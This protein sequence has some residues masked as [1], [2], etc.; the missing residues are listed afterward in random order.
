MDKSASYNGL[1]NFRPSAGG[2]PQG[3]RVLGKGQV[4]NSAGGYTF[5]ADMWQR[6]D[7]FLI[8]G[9]DRG[10]YY[11]SPRQL[12]L[13]NAE[14]L[15]GC[16]G[17]NAQRTIQRI[18]DISVSGRAPHNEPCIFA[19]AV[20]TGHRSL[21]VRRMALEAVGRVCRTATHLFTF[22]GYI[23]SCGIRRWGR[24]LRGAVA[25]W[26]NEK[27]ASE[28]AYQVIK[29]RARN[30]WTHK[31]ALLLAHAKP[32]TPAHAALFGYVFA[33]ARRQEVDTSFEPLV[34]GFERLQRA[35][36]A[37]EA[38]RLILQYSLPWEAV[39]GEFLG[40]ARV[41]AALLPHMAPIA[42]IRTLNRMTIAGLLAP[43]S[44]A[45]KFVVG[46]LSDREWLRKARLH[47][48]TYFLMER[49]YAQGHGL[50]GGLTWQPLGAV[51]DALDEAFYGA[52]DF[53]P[54]SGKNILLALDV[55]G[56]MDL[57]MIDGVVTAREGAAIMAMAQAR[58][59]EHTAFMAFS[60]TFVPLDISKGMRLTDVV[61]A[62]RRLP[63]GGTD[64]ALPML[65]ALGMRQESPRGSLWGWG[66]VTMKQSA[67]VVPNI[68]GFVVYTDNETWCGAIHPFQALNRYRAEANPAARLAV[69]AMTSNG[70][71][72]ADPAA[73][74]MLD[75]VGLDAATPGLISDFMSGAL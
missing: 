71:T 51:V 75:C 44:E 6:L 2:T 40:D 48:Y 5:A 25:R 27:S 29:Y 31:D 22:L 21:A 58:A 41:W 52:F 63:M 17:A 7:R 43:F 3:E 60:D 24:G 45:S 67:P 23:K 20:A 74:Y 49:T 16:L 12:T 18:V 55:S 70:F 65:W 47:P 4:Q 59:E 15:L 38:A 35:R 14:N 42:M 56:S 57:S 37:G 30:G 36:E 33:S 53:L 28:A 11:A 73:D 19:L 32:A 66:R 72:I 34:E 1:I 68:D 26:Y 10:S 54:S 39:P 8:L 50:R 61:R 62:T 9:S 64:C 13:E 69:V 46:R